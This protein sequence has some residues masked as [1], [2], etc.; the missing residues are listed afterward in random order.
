LVISGE[1]AHKGGYYVVNA[2]AILTLEKYEEDERRHR[3]QIK[4]QI[5]MIV[6]TGL[7]AIFAMIQAEIIKVPCLLDFTNLFD[8]RNK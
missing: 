3:H 1:L 8:V 2:K 6:L 5:F 7:L 4:L